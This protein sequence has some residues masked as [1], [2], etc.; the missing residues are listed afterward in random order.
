MRPRKTW[1]LF[2]LPQLA[3]FH[4]AHLASYL[5]KHGVDAEAGWSIN[6][7]LTT[8]REVNPTFRRWMFRRSSAGK[9]GRRGEY[10]LAVAR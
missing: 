1:C 7:L 10:C 8:M 2:G 3:A 5:Q 4:P 6:E 9:Q